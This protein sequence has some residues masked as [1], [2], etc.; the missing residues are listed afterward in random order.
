M[1]SL[2]LNFQRAKRVVFAGFLTAVFGIFLSAPSAIYAGEASGPPAWYPFEREAINLYLAGVNQES[3]DPAGAVK[4]LLAARQN[5]SA[6]IRN[7]G[8]GNTAVLHNDQLI[9]RALMTAQ[10]GAVGTSENNQVTQSQQGSG[11][12]QVKPGSNRIQA[13][14]LH[15]TTQPSLHPSV[16]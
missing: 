9:A 11:N 5:S 3:S 13:V 10:A 14:G 4:T 16:H 6:A 12:N 2:R 15:T 8:G 1:K 7:G